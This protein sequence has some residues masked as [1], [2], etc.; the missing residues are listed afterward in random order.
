MIRIERITLRLPAAYAPRA[1]G[2]ARAL[3]DELAGLTQLGPLEL[4]HVVVP[5]IRIPAALSEG[6]VGAILARAVRSGIEGRHG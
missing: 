3:G 6:A 5:P 2:I 4:E 1:A